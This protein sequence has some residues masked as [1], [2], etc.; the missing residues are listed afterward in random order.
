MIKIPLQAGCPTGVHT[1]GARR[2][3]HSVAVEMGSKGQGPKTFRRNQEDNGSM[4]NSRKM[5]MLIYEV[6]FK[7]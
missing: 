1:A 5:G 3:G 6:D 2:W 4:T 7:F